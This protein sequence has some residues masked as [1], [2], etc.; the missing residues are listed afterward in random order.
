MSLHEW[1]III[2][3]IG[4]VGL[5]IHGFQQKNRHLL[6]LQK[7]LQEAGL[8]I[9]QMEEDHRQKE[10]QRENTEDKLRSYLHLLDALINTMSN[11]IC[12]KDEQGIFQGCNQVFAEQVLGLTR[13]RIIGN[14]AQDLP[15]QIPPDLAALYQ[16]Q[17][18]VIL[19]RGD[20]HAFEAQVRCADGIGRDF[21]FSLA[22]IQSHKGKTIGTVAVLSDLTDKNRAVQDRLLKEKL[23]SALETAGGV[24]HEFNQP[25]QVLSGNLEILAVKVKASSEALDHIEKAMGQIERMQTITDK[26]QGITRYETLAYAGN[27]KIIDIHKSSYQTGQEKKEG[28]N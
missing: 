24:C 4:F 10:A 22:P 12:F 11:P 28:I 18:T 13:D 9:H 2:L 20:F 3:Y 8:K 5:C 6:I 15:E 14:R 19:E 1:L 27:S 23:E 7:A 16:R 17:E 26:L 21:L 25:L